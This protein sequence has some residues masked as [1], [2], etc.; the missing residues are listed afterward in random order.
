M[1][2]SLSGKQLKLSDKIQTIKQNIRI[3]ETRA[4]SIPWYDFRFHITI[5]F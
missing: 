2:L 5:K 4:E 3:L 1:H